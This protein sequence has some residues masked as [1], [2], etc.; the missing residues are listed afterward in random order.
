MGVRVGPRALTLIAIVCGATLVGY[1]ARR[2]VGVLPDSVQFLTAANRFHDAGRW[3]VLGRDGALVPLSQFPPLYPTALAGAMMVVGERAWQATYPLHVGLVAVNLWLIAALARRLA[4]G[5]IWAGVVAVVM[6]S[7]CLG[8]V[9]I[10]AQAMSEPLFLTL[11]LGAWLALARI[12][13]RPTWGAMVASALF[14]ALSALTR[15][16]GI[17]MILAAT[18]WLSRLR[19]MATS[20]RRIPLQ[21][22]CAW[23]LL[24]TL[25]IAWWLVV[26]SHGTSS[27]AGRAPAVHPPTWQDGQVLC[28]T[29]CGWVLPIDLPPIVLSSLTTA[30]P[31]IVALIVLLALRRSGRGSVVQDAAPARVR[32]QWELLLVLWVGCYF[33]TLL[34]VR[35]IVDAALA[36]D[37]RMLLPV[38]VLAIAFVSAWACRCWRAWGARTRLAVAAALVLVGALHAARTLGWGRGVAAEGQGFGAESWRSSAM[39]PYLKGIDPDIAI[40]SNAP[41]AVYFWTGRP[42]RMLPARA[43]AMSLAVNERFDEQMR[44]LDAAVGQDRAM[45]VFFD[46]V[47]WRW[48]LPDLEGCR[49]G[50][51][52]AIRIRTGAAT[53]FRR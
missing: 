26:A 31:L 17:A 38:Q 20:P 47:G 16:T 12:P 43:D 45:V 51:S 22:A 53:V 4:Q 46:A 33:F 6:A 13:D 27:I 10:H 14:C 37:D 28:A 15:Y 18:M 9:R 29:L 50:F 19:A 7:L 48:Y 32:S 23:G 8:F 2:G 30:A 36:F 5:S 21:R 44:S 11:T 3:E 49:A 1:S 34:V 41:D 42:A 24:A 39:W 52:S 40:Y 35:W 25:P